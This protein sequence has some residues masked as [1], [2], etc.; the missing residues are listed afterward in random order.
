[1]CLFFEGFFHIGNWYSWLL[2]A[3]F[4]RLTYACVLVLLSGNLV[5]FELVYLLCTIDS[6]ECHCYSCVFL[7][8]SEI[9]L[10]VVIAE[11]GDNCV[12]G[13]SIVLQNVLLTCVHVL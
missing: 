13:S 4:T 8:V 10:T 2:R 7:M 9:M 5:C 6:A 12:Q 1:M 3:Y 11:C